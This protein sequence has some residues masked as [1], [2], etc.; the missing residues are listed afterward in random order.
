MNKYSTAFENMVHDLVE[1]VDGSK[2]YHTITDSQY[3]DFKK[4]WTFDAI[5][6]KRYGQAF[7]DYFNIASTT[8]LY[9]FRDT[10]LCEH[11]IKDN[12]LISGAP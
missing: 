6:G 8:P 9:H 10:W 3:E 12:Y 11:W 1:L 4:Q 2:L 5:A 7:C